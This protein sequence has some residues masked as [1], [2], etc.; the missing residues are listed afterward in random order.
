MVTTIHG[1]S[2]PGILPFYKKYN[3]SETYVTINDA[4][5]SPDLDDIKTVHHGIDIRQFDFLPAPADQLLFFGRI[6]HEK[7]TRKALKIAM[8]CGT[9]PVIAFSK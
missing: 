5:R 4:D 1:F 8:A 3:P 9:T 6:H 2:S 7:G